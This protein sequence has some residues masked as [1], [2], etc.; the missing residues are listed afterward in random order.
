MN[1][2]LPAAETLHR[3]ALSILEKSLGDGDPQVAEVLF[4]L[5]AV[6]GAQRERLGETEA[7]LHRCLDAQRRLHDPGEFFTLSVAISFA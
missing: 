7:L 3:E 6:V 1:G 5:A 2:D 4:N